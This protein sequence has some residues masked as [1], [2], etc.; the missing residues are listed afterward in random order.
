MTDSEA[1]NQVEASAPSIDIMH[2]V[3]LLW[4]WKFFI[5][6]LGLLF[7]APVAY[8][9]K[10][11]PNTYQATASLSIDGNEQSNIT[12]IQGLYGIDTGSRTY[13]STQYEV[14]RSRNL[15]ERVVNDLNLLEHP[16]FN[17]ISANPEI[18]A[19]AAQGIVNSDEKLVRV[20][21]NFGRSLR[22]APLNNTSIVRIS[23]STTDPQLA[24]DV[25]NQVALS[26]IQQDL[27]NRTNQTSQASAWLSDRASRLNLEL[28]ESEIVLQEFLER[29]QLVDIGGVASLVNQEIDSLSIQLIETQRVRREA[30]TIF[31][32]IQ[33][34][35]NVSPISLL[36]F[37][38][39]LNNGSVESAK[40]N[41]D[42]IKQEIAELSN[43]YGRN[44]PRMIALDAESIRADQNLKDTVQQLINSIESQYQTA[45]ENER[46]TAARLEDSKAE[47][48]AING[49][50][51]E[52]RELEREVDANRQLYEM[53]FTRNRETQE[54]ND[55][56][57]TNATI[58]DP[59]IP[60]VYPTGPQR[61]KTVLMALMA[62]LALGCGLPLLLDIL[63]NTARSYRDIETRIRKN[64]LG[65]VP[66]VKIAKK[67]RR[68]TSDSKANEHPSVL[69][70]D[71]DSSF[72]E[73]FRTIR[74]GVLL[75]SIDNPH[76]IMGI[77]S[78]VPEEGK[79]TVAINLATSL[80]LMGRR[81]LL[82]DTD[83]RRPSLQKYTGLP[84]NSPGLADY[85]SG[86]NEIKEILYKPNKSG[87][88]IMP[89]GR[90][91]SDPL[92]LLSS[93]TLKRLLETLLSTYDQ[94]V[95]DTPPTLAVSDSLIL[96][97]IADAMI[98]VVKADSTP[99]NVAKKQIERL[100]KADANVIGVV[101]NQ[102]DI[103]KSSDYGG[104]YDS[105]GYSKAPEQVS[106]GAAG[107]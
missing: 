104:Y 80:A 64:V 13:T 43:R 44:H 2:Y 40:L 83:L 41:A 70:D 61:K 94:I 30:E 87:L 85:L 105:Y 19:G 34:V 48:Q 46:S 86:A 22:I 35:E 102:L 32:Q 1:F 59:A 71:A 24:A 23:F 39:I 72:V 63:N 9:A 62:G 93:N 38:V 92:E 98:F 103:R 90:F 12:N 36:T 17:P 82:I 33:Q 52:R 88:T 31:R 89:S 81:V 79:S 107:T 54:T 67:R 78:S 97:Q 29:E 96:S 73:A 7:S 51:F 76:K 49:S 47:L 101:L 10:D 106:T 95:M 18:N 58:I 21:D 20:L 91:V 56:Q 68:K 75:S 57:T 69:N 26:Y 15:A 100:H 53:L 60:P 16:V 99:M 55:L 74:T 14:L 4:R 8:L 77:T 84:P 5:A 28:R 66:I 50:S 27:E 42:Q 65:V 11:W 6:F 37:P 3:R 45:L 25:A